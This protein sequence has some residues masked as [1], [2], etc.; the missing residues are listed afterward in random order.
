VTQA[1]A[2]KGKPLLWGKDFT[3]AKSVSI[4]M[5][6]RNVEEGLHTM[7][8]QAVAQAVVAYGGSAR[9]GDVPGGNVFIV[10]PTF[11]SYTSTPIEITAVVRRNAANENSGFKLVY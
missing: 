6:K 1:S 2:N 11:L 8:G 10:D 9:A 4:S 3:G 5:G 7:S